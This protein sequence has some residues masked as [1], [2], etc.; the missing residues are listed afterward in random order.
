[1]PDFNDLEN[2][3]PPVVTRVHAGDGRFLA[4]FAQERRIFVP[5]TEI[6]DIVTEAFTSAEDKNFFEHQGIDLIG[7]ARAVIN[8]IPNIIKNRRTRKNGRK[9]RRG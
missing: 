1:L 6:P 7:L 2:Y 9:I 8:N 5:I 4:E 3:N